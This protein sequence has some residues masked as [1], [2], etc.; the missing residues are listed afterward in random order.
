MAG[1]FAVFLVYLF[2]VLTCWWTFKH[3]KGRTITEVET[4][5][6]YRATRMFLREHEIPTSTRPDDCGVS[7]FLSDNSIIYI[8]P[9]E[10]FVYFLKFTVAGDKFTLYQVVRR[11][12]LEDNTTKLE[13][14]MD[15]YRGENTW[16]TF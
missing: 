3:Q 5:I 11:M 12:Y 15:V 16:R 10:D 14:I 9:T 6:L 8:Y 7:D 1:V 4:W 2:I 13:Q